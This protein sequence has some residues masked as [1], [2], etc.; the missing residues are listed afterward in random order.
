MRAGR[1]RPPDPLG[2]RQALEVDRALTL[3]QA[4]RWY[5]VR[6]PA[7][8][9]LGVFLREV[10][11]RPGRDSV[12]SAAARVAFL[13]REGSPE[14]EL[15]GFEL[16]H[17]AGLA[18]MRRHLRAAPEEWRLDETVV[19]YDS[20]PDALW[21]PR[22]GGVWAVE[23]DVGYDRKRVR[24]KLRA[25]ARNYTGVVWGV[26]AKERARTVSALALELGVSLRLVV[27]PWR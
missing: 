14:A 24:A 13:V 15:E 3:E 12:P 10:E 11:L 23:Y 20:T 27:A 6:R 5:G 9:P 18:A 16:R 4:A 2:L 19:H 7:D 17:L 8:L 21:Y 26:H 1:L 22:G 25:F